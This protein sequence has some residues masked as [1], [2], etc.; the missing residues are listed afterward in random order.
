[1]EVLSGQGGVVGGLLR[2]PKAGRGPTSALHGPLGLLQ[3]GVKV[4]GIVFALDGSWTRLVCG[5]DKKGSVSGTPQPR[6]PQHCV[7]RR[8]RGRCS[9]S[10][11]VS[12]GPPGRSGT[13]PPGPS[14]A[15][16]APAGGS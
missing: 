11:S 3:Q 13:E 8:Y 12:S 4:R 9:A 7:A 2:G 1:M 10:W 5:R 15:W 16:E 6:T 14:G